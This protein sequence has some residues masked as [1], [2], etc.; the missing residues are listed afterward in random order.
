MQKLSDNELVE[1]WS[2]CPSNTADDKNNQLEKLYLATTNAYELQDGCIIESRYINDNMVISLVHK[3]V[4]PHVIYT[5]VIFDLSPD[6][7]P[8]KSRIAKYCLY[9]NEIFNIM[10]PIMT[11]QILQMAKALEDSISKKFDRMMLEDFHTVKHRMGGQLVDVVIKKNNKNSRGT[12][13]ALKL[14]E[15]IKGLP[16]HLEEKREL[17]ERLQEVDAR[18]KILR[19]LESEFS[20]TG[21]LQQKQAIKNESQKTNDFSH[22]RIK[23]ERK[24]TPINSSIII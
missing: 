4:S 17:E 8:E 16:R 23:E 19:S 1:C 18:E 12:A 10:R 6:L 21:A 13:G 14:C 11:W 20:R 5:L 2:N 9:K 3:E 15:I 22:S 7:P 24:K